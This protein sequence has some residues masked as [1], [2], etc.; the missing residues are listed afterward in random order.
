MVNINNIIRFGIHV[1]GFTIILIIYYS[2]VLLYANS[3]SLLLNI[4]KIINLRY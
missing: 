3:D 2:L 4:I 1:I